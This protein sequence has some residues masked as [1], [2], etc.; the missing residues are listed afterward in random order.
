MPGTEGARQPFFSPDSKS[1]GFW[2][3]ADAEIR[4]VA[5]GGGSST[6]MCRTPSGILYGA[7]WGPGDTIV[8]AVVRNLYRVAAT[9]GTPQVLTTPDAATGEFE[10]RWPEILPDGRAVVFTVWGGN[11]ERARIASRSLA[12]TR[13]SR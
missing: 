4:R 5:L 6:S 13:S 2:S 8:F 11:F 3:P 7:S 9:G 1:V 10:H 12:P